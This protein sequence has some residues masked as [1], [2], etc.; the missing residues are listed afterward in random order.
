MF[1][2]IF[3]SGRHDVPDV[4]FTVLKLNRIHH[5]HLLHLRTPVN[6]TADLVNLSLRSYDKTRIGVV[7]TES[8]IGVRLQFERKRNIHRPC[9]QNAEF[10]ENPIVATLRNQSHLIS[11]FKAH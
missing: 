2:E 3:L 9:I 10:A 5:N 6:H 7:D 8:Q 11:F 1:L 4:Y